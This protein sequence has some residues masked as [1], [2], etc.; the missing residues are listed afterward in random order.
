MKKVDKF[1]IDPFS[2]SYV[3]AIIL[4]SLL[5]W[6]FFSTQNLA[7]VPHLT[8]LKNYAA[9]DRFDAPWTFILAE[10]CPYYFWTRKMPTRTFGSLDPSTYSTARLESGGKEERRGMR[11]GREREGA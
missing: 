4:Q 6:L 7:L 2:V 9:G 8:S 3:I 11:E 1:H 10:S 5:K